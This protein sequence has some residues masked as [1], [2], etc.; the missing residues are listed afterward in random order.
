MIKNIYEIL[1]E[2]ELAPTKQE[3]KQILQQN[4]LFH[5]KE[6]LKYTFDKKYQFYVED[7]FPTDYIEPDTAPGIRYAG[8]ESEIRRT[9]LFVKGDPTADSLTEQKRKILLLQLLESFEPKEARIYFNML[10]KDL[11]IKGLTEALVREVYPDLLS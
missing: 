2:F 3:K 8:I 9:Y 4:D 7:K 11:K 6:L 10:K 1:D 5:L